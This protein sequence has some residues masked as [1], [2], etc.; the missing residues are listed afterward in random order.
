MGRYSK[1]IRG[2]PIRRKLALAIV[3]VSVG[4]L[5]FSSAIMTY[6]AAQDKKQSIVSS[7]SLTAKIIG[8]N[9]TTALT[10]EDH[11]AA[12]E[13]LLALLSDE[14]IRIGCIYDQNFKLFAEYMISWDEGQECPKV[15]DTGLVPQSLE[16]KDAAP[17]EDAAYFSLESIVVTHSIFSNGDIVG[18]VYIM[19]DMSLINKFIE[20]Q[21]YSLIGIICITIVLVFLLTS[22]LQ[23]LIADP[24]VY[25]TSTVQKIADTKDYSTRA[26]KE[27][28]DEFGILAAAFNGMLDVIQTR[29]LELKLSELKALN[30]QS[31][32]ERINAQLQDYTDK[33][34]EARLDAFEAKD[35]AE[36][37]NRA[38]SDFLANMSHEIRTPMNAILGMSNFLLDTKLNPEQKECASAVKTA[39]DTLLSIINDIIDISKIEAGKMVLEQTDFD[40]P[41]TVNE[42]MSLYSYQ[43]RE[44]N[45]EMMMEISPDV[46]RLYKGDPVRM[47]QVFG[48]LISNALKFTSSGHILVRINKHPEQDGEGR[49]HLICA[50]EDTGIGIPQ[51]KQ[52]KIFEKFSQADE[53]TTRRFGGTGLGLA[54]V[55]H[56]IELMGGSIRAESAEGKG[57]QF[58]FDIFLKHGEQKTDPAVS[59]DLSSLRVLIIDDYT[60]TRDLIAALLR[61]RNISCTAV[62]SA[63]EALVILEKGDAVYD[64]CFVDYALEGMNGIKFVQKLR[65]KAKFDKMSL[66]MIS[67]AMRKMQHEEMQA[68]GLDGYFNKPF[69]PE[70]I[71]AAL[72][73]TV[74]NRKN[75]IKNAPIMTRHNSLKVLKPGSD[76]KENS[77]RQYTGRKVLAVDDAKLNMIVIQKVLKKFGL[78]VDTAT[79]GLE[80]LEL[81]KKNAYDAVFMDCQMPEMD[82]FEATQEIRKFEREHDRR[83]TPIIALTADAMIGDREKCLGFGM[84]DYLNKPFKEI[85]IAQMLDKWVGG[86][87]PASV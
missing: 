66:I 46:P 29:Q 87:I 34:E 76:T 83:N 24:I 65:K 14:S 13:K 33:L 18:F 85:E 86:E 59:E 84:S 45:I 41:E 53:S 8:D 31:E 80:A 57:S 17:S 1:I 64:S 11:D 58:I 30:A 68:A 4:V 60:L 50:V 43:A 47:K 3:S 37:A 52:K 56:L 21:I 79:N 36:A 54:I 23:K 27:T 16:G 25:L 10:H 75:G 51:E 9:S 49:T 81:V 82:G 55:S 73:I 67:G 72:K 48:N 26:K 15:F 12:A 19:S 63:E 77:F 2:L 35:K 61:R 40:F 28:D 62:A 71:I 78:E 38:K 22:W 44:K 42:V 69:E 5:V 74:D 70:Q 7:L 20:Q 32:A 39:G 6:L